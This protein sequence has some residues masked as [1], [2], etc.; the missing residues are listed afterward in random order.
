M[1][2]AQYK[3]QTEPSL[4]SQL[5]S[6]QILLLEVSIYRVL[7]FIDFHCPIEM[8]EADPVFKQWLAICL[9]TL[10]DKQKEARL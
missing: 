9:G 5:N 7:V 1:T 3:I 4:T 6:T 10:L 2:A 8:E